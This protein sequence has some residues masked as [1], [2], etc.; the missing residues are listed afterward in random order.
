MNEATHEFQELSY[1]RVYNVCLH[2]DIVALD[3]WSNAS[4]FKNQLNVFL[5]ALIQ[6][7]SFKILKIKNFRGDLT[8]ISAK[9]DPLIKSICDAK[10][11]WK[12][13][14]LIRTTLMVLSNV[15]FQNEMK[16]PS[17]TLK[18]L[19]KYSHTMQAEFCRVTELICGLKQSTDGAA[20]RKYF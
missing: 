17:E 3:E 18:I 20:H 12:W 8:D 16:C 6:I 13:F 14:P 9:K 5:D 4:V 11:I 7:H 15:Y 1:V 2:C 10:A 19:Y